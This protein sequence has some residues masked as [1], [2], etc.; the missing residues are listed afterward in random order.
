MGS[1]SVTEPLPVPSGP[2]AVDIDPSAVAR[3]VPEPPPPLE[4]LAVESLP[5]VE[6]LDVPSTI[7]VLVAA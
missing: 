1:P 2:V 7:P 5:V 6:P 3:L 4:L